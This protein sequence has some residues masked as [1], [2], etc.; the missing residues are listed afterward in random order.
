[1]EMVLD[2]ILRKKSKQQRKHEP[3]TKLIEEKVNQ[4]SF[5]VK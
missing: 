5:Y 2:I 4:T 1:M 3:P